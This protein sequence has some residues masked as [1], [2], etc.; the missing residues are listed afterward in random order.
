MTGWFDVGLVRLPGPTDC[1]GSMMPREAMRVEPGVPI[2]DAFH[3]Q[4]N[5]AI[6]ETQ[7]TQGSVG[8]LCNGDGYAR[9]DDASA[10]ALAYRQANKSPD[11]SSQNGAVTLDGGRLIGMGHNHFPVGTPEDWGSTWG[12]RD[13]KYGLVVHAEVAATLDGIGNQWF[14][15]TLACIWYACTDCA[16]VIISAGIVRCVGHANHRRFAASVNPRWNDSIDLALR[17]LERAGVAC[18]WYEGP[19]D[20]PSVLIGG[21]WFDPS[22]S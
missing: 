10:L 21:E 8:T 13:L 14:P 12:D 7:K 19:I 11:P 6:S 3:T 5:G 22:C 1:E 2:T 16:K 15:D 18:D 9:L 20:A 4:R 17:M